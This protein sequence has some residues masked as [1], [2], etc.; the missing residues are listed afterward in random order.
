MSLYLP[1]CELM[2]YKLKKAVTPQI[3]EKANCRLVANLANA[4]CAMVRQSLV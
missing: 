4:E 2:Q 3:Q 1:C